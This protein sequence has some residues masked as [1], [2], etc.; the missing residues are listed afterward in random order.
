MHP[1]CLSES[2]SS[3]LLQVIQENWRESGCVETKCRWGNKIIFQAAKCYLY[4]LMS[5]VS[6][7]KSAGEVPGHD[8]KLRLT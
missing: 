5:Q 8:G 7:I 4:N 3:I 1:S 6:D 2:V